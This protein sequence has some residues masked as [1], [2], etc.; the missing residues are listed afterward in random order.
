MKTQCPGCKT[1]MAHDLRGLHCL[2]CAKPEFGYK[3]MECPAC[4]SPF[5]A[6]VKP[7]RDGTEIGFECFCNEC[8]ESWNEPTWDE[9]AEAWLEG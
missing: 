9:S 3:P 1:D 8:A 6:A 5:T 2:D 4:D 7:Y